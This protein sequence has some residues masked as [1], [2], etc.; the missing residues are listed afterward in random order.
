[1]DV[2]KTLRAYWVISNFGRM[3]VA[4]TFLTF[5]HSKPYFLAKFVLS[6]YKEF[7]F[8]GAIWCNIL[9]LKLDRK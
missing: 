4:L 8:C 3:V 7:K 5:N 9:S 2:K 1:M 6:F